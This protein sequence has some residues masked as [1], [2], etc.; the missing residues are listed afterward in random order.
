MLYS[1]YLSSWTTL[2]RV[3][4]LEHIHPWVVIKM[5][6]MVHG[7]YISWNKFIIDVKIRFRV[8]LASAASFNYCL[9]ASVFHVIMYDC[10]FKDRSFIK[11]VYRNHN[12][13]K[14]YFDD[15]ES[16]K[17]FYSLTKWIRQNGKATVFH[18]CLP[19]PWPWAYKTFFMLNSSD[20]DFFPAHK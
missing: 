18:Y 4:E 8:K 14:F 12:K 7:T 1:L 11:V 13:V 20:H 15:H 2:H 10:K 16:Y 19:S 9:E 17:I 6:S 3:T 5:F